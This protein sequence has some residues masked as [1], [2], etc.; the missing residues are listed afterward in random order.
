[1]DPIMDVALHAMQVDMARLER[2]GANLANALTPGYRREVLVQRAG[3]MSFADRLGH[4]AAVDASARAAA[5]ADVLRD[6][7]PGTLRP[8]GQ[9]FD[10]A[11]AGPGFF[12]LATP[13][14]PAY[15]RDGRFRLDER[16]R[17]VSATGHPVMGAAGEIVL[18]PGPVAID[19]RGVVR[20]G[21]QALAQLRVVAVDTP[22]ALLPAGDGLY[23]GAARIGPVPDA[24]RQV[25]QGFLENA[26]VDPMHEMVELMRTTRHFE[27]LSRVLQGR[28][29][30]LGAALRRLGEF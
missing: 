24:E 5:G 28:D 1:M 23:A 21:G 2:L 18:L 12:E 27:T 11:L 3:T 10:L 13:A 4:E 29:E 7:R 15:T 20:Q 26:N 6:W 25:R 8:T 19:A 17:L 22:Q 16:G 30:M 14:G 9:P